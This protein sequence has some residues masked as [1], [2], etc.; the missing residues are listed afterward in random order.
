MEHCHT[1]YLDEPTCEWIANQENVDFAL[2]LPDIQDHSPPGCFR[3][4]DGEYIV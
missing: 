4:S 3:R 2:V 1:S